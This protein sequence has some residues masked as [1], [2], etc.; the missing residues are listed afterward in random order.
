[1]MVYYLRWL[2]GS[3]CDWKRRQEGGFQSAENVPFL[4]LVLVAGVHF[5]SAKFNEPYTYMSSVCRLCFS[6]RL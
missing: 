4:H 3:G 6:K 1:M 2:G 5:L